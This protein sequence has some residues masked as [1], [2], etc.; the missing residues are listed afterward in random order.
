YRIMKQRNWQCDITPAVEELG[1]SPEYDLER[2][3]KETIA[4]YKDKGWL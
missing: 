4:W 3:V 2:G 1:F